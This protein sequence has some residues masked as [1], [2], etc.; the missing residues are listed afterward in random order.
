MQFSLE[1]QVPMQSWK[2]SWPDVNRIEN[3]PHRNSLEQIGF[4]MPRDRERIWMQ[5]WMPSRVNQTAGRPG[6]RISS[7]T[8]I[9][10]I[11]CLGKHPRRS[12]RKFKVS[13]LW[14]IGW[15]GPERPKWQVA[16]KTKGH[17]QYTRQVTR[18][19]KVP[20]QEDTSR[21]Q[22]D[23]CSRSVQGPDPDTNPDRVGQYN[24][25]HRGRGYNW[26]GLEFRRGW[27]KSIHVNCAALNLTLKGQ[28]MSIEFIYIMH[29]LVNDRVET[30]LI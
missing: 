15:L 22:K 2:F 7:S 26:P 29:L 8:G 25:E 4:Y 20:R 11:P 5:L 9:W 23:T 16:R 13:G 27:V 17:L 12:S 3:G 6:W 18:K 10:M 14:V 19:L 28:T 24:P 21:R 1:I 30:T